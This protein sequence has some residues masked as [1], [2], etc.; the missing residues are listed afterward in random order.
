MSRIVALLQRDR[1]PADLETLRRLA[2]PMRIR[3][4]DEPRFRLSGPAALAFQC[5]QAS[6]GPD[7]L[8]PAELGP[9]LSICFD[10]RLDGSGPLFCNGFDQAELMRSICLRPLERGD[11]FGMGNGLIHRGLAI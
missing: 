6:T 4:S 8:Q 5:L 3:G 11:E 9:A 10:G 1:R 2:A 7:D